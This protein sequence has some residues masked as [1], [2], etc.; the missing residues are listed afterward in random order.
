MTTVSRVILISEIVSQ[1]Q[2]EFKSLLQGQLAADRHSL[3]DRN[4]NCVEGYSNICNR[5]SAVINV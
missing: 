4:D 3:R 2:L 1:L 5:R